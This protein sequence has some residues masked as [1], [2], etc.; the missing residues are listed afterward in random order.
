MQVVVVHARDRILPELSESLGRY[1]QESMALRGVTFRLNCRLTDYRPG[2]I[3]LSEGEIRARTLVWTAGTAPNPLLKTLPIE[4]D[5]RGAVIVES[6]M[7]VAGHSGVWAVG[8][9]AALK[10][11]KTGN[12][13]PP[14]AQL[15]GPERRDVDEQETAV[16]RRRRLA[17][18]LR[19]LQVVGRRDRFIHDGTKE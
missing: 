7:A 9:C 12:S 11:G 4:T 10:D 18:E 8:D 6:T 2:N 17:Q 15:L 3:V 5:R 16:N 1:A 14:T 13:C 19:G